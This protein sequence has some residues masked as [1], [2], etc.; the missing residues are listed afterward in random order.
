MRR[1]GPVVVRG[2]PPAGPVDELV[3][4]DE[5]PAPHVRLKRAGR[6]RGDDALDA[7]LL[8]RP[9]VRAVGDLVRRVLVACDR[10]AGGTRRARPLDLADDERRRRLA[11]RRVDLDLFDVVEERVEPRAPEYADRRATPPCVSSS[12][13]RR[14]SSATTSTPSYRGLDFDSELLRSGVSW[15]S[16]PWTSRS[17]TRS[18]SIPTLDSFFDSGGGGLR[19]GAR[20]YR[21]SR[22]PSPFSTMPT[23]WNTRLSGPPQCSQVR[24]GSSE[25][26]WTTSTCRPQDM[27]AYSYVG[28]AGYGS[29]SS[30]RDAADRRGAR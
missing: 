5:V 28:I 1:L 3:A 12:T 9:E 20:G 22:S 4:H 17:S 27:H 30:R 24:S 23:G 8:E 2:G 15:L 14:S 11:V 16:N 21:S 26:L 18:P 25:K 7:Q 29:G 19:A 10:A 13:R 6:G